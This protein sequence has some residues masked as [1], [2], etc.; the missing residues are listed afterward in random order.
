MAKDGYDYWQLPPELPPRALLRA[1]SARSKQ[2]RWLDE[3]PHPYSFVISN[4]PQP[5]EHSKLLS[6]AVGLSAA[7][8]CNSPLSSTYEKLSMWYRLPRHS[9]KYRTE[10]IRCALNSIRCAPIGIEK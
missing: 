3:D 4:I 9:S 10:K 5:N 6:I 2:R 7:F 1:Q 8:S